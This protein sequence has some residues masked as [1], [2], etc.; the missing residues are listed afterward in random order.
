MCY[1][2]RGKRRLRAGWGAMRRLLKLDPRPPSY[3]SLAEAALDVEPPGAVT[4]D[5][6]CQTWRAIPGPSGLRPPR[7]AFVDGVQRLEQRISAE[8]EGLPIPGTIVSYA[9]GA[10][11][12]GHEPPLGHVSVQRRVLLAK[13]AQPAAIRLDAHNGCLDYLPEHSAGDDFVSLYRTLNDC[14]ANLEAEVI[15]RLMLERPELIVVDGRLPDVRHGPAIGFVKT[16]QTLYVSDPQHLDCLTGLSAGERSPVFL[17]ERARSAVYSWF[18][19]LANPGPLDLALSGLARLEMDASSARAEVLRMA[20]LTT[21]ILPGY[22]SSP[23]QDDRAPQNLLPLGQ[24]ERELRHRL[25]D[26][27]LLRRLMLEAFTREAPGWNP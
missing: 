3:A 12:P 15:R 23:M 6:E 27:E 16:L 4:A 19:C 20:D 18:V 17:I 24:L 7:L 14:R 1:L 8:G 26:P 11:T 10:V 25:G 5:V 9:A 22:A 13:G 21:S 2:S